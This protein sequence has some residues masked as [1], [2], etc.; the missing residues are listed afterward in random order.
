[1]SRV[2]G[3]PQTRRRHKKIMKLAKGYRG[4]R[5]RHYKAA[6]EQVMRALMYSY[7]GRKQRKRDFRRLWIMRINAAARQHG[8]K[9]S[10]LIFALQSAGAGIDRKV[11]AD[12]AVSDPEG[13]AKIAELA[14]AELA[15]VRE[16]SG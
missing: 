11:L 9:Y 4:A 5:S 14:K 1:M 16:G 12:I 15:K 13:F 7:R 2:T 8:L 10:D 3:G 6:K